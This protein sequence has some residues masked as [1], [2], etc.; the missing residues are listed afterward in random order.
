MPLVSCIM[1]T[2]NRRRFVPQAIRLFLAQDYPERELVILD[3]GDDPIADLVPVDPKI[4]YLRH[5]RREPIGT[6]RNR[7]CE[8]ARGD[9][10][11]H[12]DDD[13][14]Y[15]PQRLRLQV[16]A[17]VA[18]DAD[19][20]GLDRVLF[21]DPQRRRAWE[22]VYPSGGARWVC[23]AT[24]CYRKSLW[25]RTPFPQINIGEDTRFVASL[26]GARV[27][28]QP[29]TDI[30]VGMIHSANT[31]P[32]HIDDGRWQPRPIETIASVMGRDWLEY[33]NG[34]AVEPRPS[35]HRPAALVTAASGIGDSLRV[36]PL[37]RVLH[38]LGHDVDLLLAPDDP[39]TIELLHGAPELRRI[40]HY[41]G[42]VQN[43]GVRPV[44][45]LAG[46][47]YAVATFT[48]WSAPLARWVTAQRHY[49]FSRT[50]W[51]A[52]GDTASIDK[53]ARSL[54]WDGPLPEPFAMTSGRIF[55]V[56]EGTIALHPGCKTG[57]PW[58]KWHG[59][60]GLARLLPQVAIIGTASDLD[61][62]GTYFA[63]PFDWPEHARNF[64]GTLS[65]GDT[66]ALI[67]QCAALISNDS[68][69][70][71]L[72]VALGVPTFGIFGITNPQREMIRSRWMIPV[73]KRLPCEA[74]CRQQP[75]G[76]RD[77]EHH[78]EC[79][80][81]LTPDEVRSR[82][83]ESLPQF[84]RAVPPRA[85]PAMNE[86]IRV[87]Y[88][89]EVS[90]A[91]GYGQAARLY[92]HALHRAGVELSVV[93][94]GSDLRQLEDPLV[95]SLLG[96]NA[97][98]DF[99][100]F[101]GIPPFWARTAYPLRNVIALTVWETDTMPPQ[102]RNPLTHAIDVW[103]PC[104]FNVEVFGRGLG[105]PPFRLPHPAPVGGPCDARP[106]AA[107]AEQLGVSTEDFVFYSIF[108]WQ[109]RKNP[110]GLIEAFLRS[111]SQEGDAV[112]ILKTNPSARAVATQAVE[113]IRAASGS[114]GQIVL[115]CEA[116]SEARISALHER[117]DC[118]VSLHKGEGWG[119]PLF[120]AACR[121]KP[122]VVTAYA[123]PLDYLDR[124]YHWLVRNRPTTVR[125]RYLYYHPGMSWAEPDIGHAGE[126]LTWIYNHRDEA[127]AG[128]AEAGRQLS[129]TF[130]L[131]RV[132][133]MAKGRLI[134]LLRRSH[135]K[136]ASVIFQNEADRLHPV[137]LPIP[138][139]WYDADYFERGRKSNW[140]RGYSWETF[141][142]VFRDAAA[143]LADMFPEA[144]TFLD[145]GCAKG[146]LVR[147]LRD[148]GL[149]AWG[150]D[151]SPWAISQ[152]DPASQSYLQLA[153]INDAG[154]DRQFDII[155]AMS[156]LESLTEEQIR[157]FLPQARH[158][159]RQALFATIPSLER[160]SD[161]RNAE[162]RDL[163]HIT[164]RPRAWWCERFLEAG[165]RQDAIH[166]YFERQCQ[167]HAL[168]TAMGWSVYVFSPMP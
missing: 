73:T 46:R 121:G 80:K 122:V 115:C 39:A 125:Q 34:A 151:H 101:H 104:N 109:E 74:A 141:K 100:L 127:R 97:D 161:R 70:M 17:L 163:S 33:A 140:E 124:K 133:E 81:M 83:A 4:R 13:D 5:H 47:D 20:C 76:R 147:A 69:L 128:A 148:R 118:Y 35:A 165:W 129:A 66:A 58:K 79:L 119:Y 11:A 62:R 86:S 96:N 37:I 12:W 30:F 7:G 57:W 82:I 93:N 51:L 131:E 89:G 23:G 41:P 150:I 38:R 16:E 146:F 136:R 42:I 166:R 49:A 149:E 106:P 91:S 144:R 8:E 2:A 107:G 85:K 134:E 120:E 114:R 94:T 167:S 27:M 25:H 9:I 145:L 77:C 54:G 154:D 45:E 160:T 53:I 117:G 75:W 142:G 111:F 40:I 72:G 48:T 157:R 50:E 153:D 14:W 132:G 67:G 162:D 135:P 158:L 159:T 26:G 164:M 71:H 78:L 44:P 63:R 143:Y 102:W 22:Y 56:P 29:E 152:A 105:R 31:S 10:I 60:D 28:A 103:L 36:T 43:R 137:T 138:G 156:I 18:A 95:Q 168:P 98:A 24:L 84:Q 113:R 116:W 139:E 110:E 32:K 87:N 112:L 68:G 90:D 108:E 64:V 130:S 15:A 55:D 61:N 155:V 52:Q 65:L 1:P 126:G 99:N 19:A 88:Y 123:G 21:L 6:K 3:D 92:V 59:F